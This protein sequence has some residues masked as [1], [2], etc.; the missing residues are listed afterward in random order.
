MIKGLTLRLPLSVAALVLGLSSGWSVSEGA[1]PYAL[2]AVSYITA[3]EPATFFS[4]DTHLACLARSEQAGSAVTTSLVCY[5]AEKPSPPPPPPPLPYGP[6][7]ELLLTGSFDQST[8][9]L[10]LPVL[11]CTEVFPGFFAVSLTLTIQLDKSGGPASG[12]VTMIEDFTAPFDCAD[13]TQSTGPLTLTPLALDHDEDGDGCSD[14][15]ELDP[16]SVGSDPFNPFDCG[17]AV[18][19]VAE[20]PEVA[21]T[22]LEAAGSSGNDAGVVAGMIGGAIAGA[23]ALGGAAWCTRLRWTGR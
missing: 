8:G 18:G 13:G 21:R 1:G 10:L 17:A 23:V 22:S 20:L 9:V 5:S 3:T 4:P 14:W 6:S 2:P 15:D 12:T 16:A 7:R 19:G 11:N